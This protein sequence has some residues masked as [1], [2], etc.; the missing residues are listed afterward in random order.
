MNH[1]FNLGDPVTDKITQYQGVVTALLFY[2]G[3][4]TQYLVKSRTLERGKSV[5]QVI[6]EP[7]LELNQAD[8][9]GDKPK[10]KFDI[11]PPN[12][13]KFGL[14]DHVKVDFT[15][16]EGQVNCIGLWM[17]GCWRYT[18]ESKNLTDGKSTSETFRDDELKL[19]KAKVPNTNPKPPTGGPERSIPS[20]V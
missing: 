17:N 14:G 16:F 1:K 5:E 2:Q 9:D 8:M 19:V 7:Q 3:A 6:E 20:S 13:L 10:T 18:V 12:E 4:I 11:I 15:G